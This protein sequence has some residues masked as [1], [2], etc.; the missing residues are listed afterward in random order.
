MLN[1]ALINL[2]MTKNKQSTKYL[3]YLLKESKKSI[4][5]YRKHL[6]IINENNYNFID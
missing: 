6:G 1:V 2:R 3:K 5:W 4:E